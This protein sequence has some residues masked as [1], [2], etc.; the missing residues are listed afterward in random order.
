MRTP[1]YERILGPFARLTTRVRP[2]YRLPLLLGLPT[3]L[4]HRINLR[5][6]N[7]SYTETAKRAAPPPGAADL[8]GARMADGSFNDLGCP[9]MGMAGARFGRNMPIA[10]TF[11]EEP[12]GLYHPNPREISRK[13]MARREF[14]PVPHLSI[15]VPAW[16]QFMVHDWLS[17]GASDTTRPPHELPLPQGDDWPGERLTVLRS[18]PDATGPGDAGRPAAY[19]NIETHWWDGSQIYGSSERRQLEVRHD[20]A[21]GTP[22][23][24]G[25]LPLD[26]RGLLPIDLTATTPDLELAGVNGNW[27]SGLSV[28]HTLFAREHNAIV[29][30]LLVEYP[31]ADGDWLFEKARLVNAALMAKIHTTEWTPALM[32]SPTGRLIMRGNWWGLL[33]EHYGRAYGRVGEGEVLSGIMGSPQDHHSAPYAMTEEFTAAYRMHSLMPDSFSFRRRAD[34]SPIVEK[35][36]TGIAGG[37]AHRL[38]DEADFLDVLYSLA[39]SHPGALVLH[40]YPAHLRTIPEKPEK[41]IFVDLA[42]TDILRDRERG[43][44]R[45]CAFR[46]RLGMS[47]PASF[48]ELTSNPTWQRELEEVY[49]S[50]EQVDFQIG[51]LAEE[52]P[53]GFGFSDTAFRV[54]ILM[55]SRRLKSD[56]FFTD[57][58]RP[59]IYTPA[60]FAWVQDNS[61]RTVMERHC[62]ALISSF[63]DVRN[64]FFPWRRGRA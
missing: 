23:A 17:H 36:L 49:G 32:N 15:L 59:E 37:N 48:A 42:T 4:G 6:Y 29:D 14:V 18:F 60:G 22:K 30:R 16:L 11:G 19:V 24:Q 12:P 8:R 35:D 44:P 64:L 39:T 28:F 34:D 45:Y 25:K 33:G 63:A 27:W 46:R 43:V 56:R 31:A 20:S 41:R 26:A 21:T 47:V 9:A 62:P 5:A 38:Y 1:W 40:N 53:P 58:F 51:M 2:W 55:A 3:L 7:L 50:V 13:L 10:D 52:A 57:D 54:F 61:L